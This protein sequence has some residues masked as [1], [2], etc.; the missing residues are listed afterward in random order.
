MKDPQ[1]ETCLFCAIVTGQ[2]PAD[3]VYADDDVVCFLPLTLNAYGHTLV[4]PRAHYETVWD[5]DR[6]C[7]LRLR[8]RAPLAQQAERCHREWCRCSP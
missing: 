7:G 1:L 2:S 8:A 6:N 3:V 4:V 5:I